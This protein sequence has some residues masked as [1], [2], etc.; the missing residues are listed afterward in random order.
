M[1]VPALGNR[2]A[3]L[4][5]AMFA[6]DPDEAPPAPGA[7][8]LVLDLAQPL[9]LRIATLGRPELPPG[10]YCYAGSGRGPG[11]LRARIGRHVRR[12]GRIHWHVDHLARAATLIGFWAVPGVTECALAE[13]ARKIPG[14]RIPVLGFGSS[15]CRI[16]PAHLIVLDRA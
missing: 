9:R 5:G 6:L 13:I 12:G 11:G 14:A 16:C 8:L 10:R 3:Q 7:Y 4:P 15:D 1:T 2:L